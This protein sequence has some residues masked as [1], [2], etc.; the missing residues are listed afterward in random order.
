[1]NDY[2][3]I[4]SPEYT[5]HIYNRV[6]GSGQ[7]FLSKDNYR[8]FLRK[9]DDYITQVA[10]TFCYCLM[11]NHFHFLIRVKE[12]KVLKEFF[13]D[14]IGEVDSSIDL[15]GFQ[16]LSGLV[17]R[18]FSNFFNAY[19]KAFNKQQD[20]NGNLFSRPYKRKLI[21]DETYLRKVIHYIHYNPVMAGIVDRP[22]N[23][24]Y[25]SYKSIISRKKTKLQRQ[26]VISYFD[27]L[28]NFKFCHLYP[29]ELT[30]IE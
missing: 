12:E 14:K 27:D 7:L 9:Y 3:S 10:D 13:K 26:E 6:I 21:S 18:Q 23:W 8:Y 28:E 24:E 16:N 15:T 19:S 11:P 29:P 20:R 2:K 5:Y 30:G 1:M 17:S 25:C 22:E 4:L